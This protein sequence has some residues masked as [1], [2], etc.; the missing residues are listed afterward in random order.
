[1]RSGQLGDLEIEFA[2]CKKEFWK[3][4]KAMLRLAVSCVPPGAMTTRVVI[5]G[6]ARH[7]CESRILLVLKFINLL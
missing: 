5:L 7:S 1:M 4:Q 2:Q 6:V 3:F